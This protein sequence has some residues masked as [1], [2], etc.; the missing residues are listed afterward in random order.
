[1]HGRVEG[2]TALITGGGSGLGREAAMH[3]AEEGAN[4]VVSDLN[5]DTAQATADE[6]NANRHAAAL[7]ARHDVSC[8]EDWA[9]VLRTTNSQF[10]SLHILLNNAGISIHGPI[11]EVAFETWKQVQEVNVDSVFWGCKLALPYMRE[12]G[13]GSIINIS[14]TAALYANPMTL[15]YGVSKASVSYMTKSVAL[16]C[17]QQRYNIRCNSIHPTF[18]KTPLL[19]RLA[20]A[21]GRNVEDVHQSLGDIVPLGEV[22]EPRDVT[23]AVIYLASDESKM[24]TGAELVIDGG[25]TAGYLPKI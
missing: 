20:D 17:A 4:I 10:G 8:E 15:S 7:A 13:G 11:E 25:L 12:T 21:A 2:K 23:F 18:I 16:H 19:E 14:S 3:L 22:L 24:M 1:M 6:I 9:D 5:E